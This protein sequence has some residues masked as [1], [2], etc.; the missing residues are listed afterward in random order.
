MLHFHCRG[1]EHLLLDYPPNIAAVNLMDNLRLEDPSNKDGFV[2]T[3]IK[4]NVVSNRNMSSHVNS[5]DYVYQLFLPNP[6][7]FKKT[8]IAFY[9]IFWRGKMTNNQ[10]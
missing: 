5:T 2:Q 4:A 1:T 8:L 6:P 10:F 3:P 7:T 9:S